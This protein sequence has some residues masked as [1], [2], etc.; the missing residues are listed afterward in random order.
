M[1]G[2]NRQCMTPCYI[3]QV[4]IDEVKS[5]S[6]SMQTANVSQFEQFRSLLV[7]L[8]CQAGSRVG[9]DCV[10]GDFQ[11]FK[12]AIACLNRRTAFAYDD[13]FPCKTGGR[14]IVVPFG[15]IHTISWDISTYSVISINLVPGF[16]SFPY[17]YSN[18]S[19][20]LPSRHARVFKASEKLLS[21]KHSPKNY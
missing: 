11:T 21:S 2:S 1:L 19:S 12:T 7:E 14:K 5:G 18:I 13:E 16:P 4:V 3:S 20:K 6:C 17:F 8:N 9:V 10:V 15:F